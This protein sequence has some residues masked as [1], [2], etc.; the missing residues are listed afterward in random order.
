MKK[1]FAKISLFLAFVTCSLLQ[2]Q[3]QNNESKPHYQVLGVASPFIDRI[4]SIDYEQFNKLEIEKGGTLV[5][6][7]PDYFQKVTEILGDPIKTTPGGSGCNTM[8]GLAMLGIECSTIG[9]VGDDQEARDF[10]AQLKDAHIFPQYKTIKIPTAQVLSLVTPDYQRTMFAFPGAS[11]HYFSEDLDFNHFLP[12]KLLHIEGYAL[13]NGDLVEKAMYL[14]R[15]AGCIVSYDMG[16]YQFAEEFRDRILDFLSAY[17]DIVFA[18]ELETKAL[19]GLEPEEGC[20][21]LMKRCPVVVVL[22]GSAGCFVG[23][24]GQVKNYLPQP[25]LVRD[26]TGAGDLF[27][28]GFLYGYLLGKDIGTC[29]YYGNL[30]GA[31]V[32]QE[33]GAIIPNEK[34]QALKQKMQN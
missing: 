5:I 29:A 12:A 34:W 18:N 14:G 24:D 8:R 22:C 26:T 23:C 13:R 17:V 6:R 16:C 30:L 3:Q 25:A 11:C 4:F 15:K 7:E 1:M 33:I 2:G 20:R 31:A 32:V 9:G 19:T 27:A 21:E 10:V 28:S